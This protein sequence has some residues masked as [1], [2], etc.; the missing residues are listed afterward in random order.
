MR[1]DTERKKN[2]LNLFDLRLEE[3]DVRAK[4]VELWEPIPGEYMLK[5]HI[6]KKMKMVERRFCSLFEK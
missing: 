2:K 6:L 3:F 5:R 4:L 1:L